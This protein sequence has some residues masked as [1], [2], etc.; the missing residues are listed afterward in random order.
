MVAM[1]SG[2][3]LGLR[4]AIDDIKKEIAASFFFPCFE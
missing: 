2:R 3:T 4:E 1:A